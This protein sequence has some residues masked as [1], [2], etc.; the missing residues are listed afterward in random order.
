MAEEVR[1]YQVHRKYLPG[2]SRGDPM[3][4][5]I[6]LRVYPEDRRPSFGKGWK[7]IA[8]S[9][10]RKHADSIVDLFKFLDVGEG[11]LKKCE[12]DVEALAG[13]ATHAMNTGGI[14]EGGNEADLPAL[15]AMGVK[16][17]Q[18]QKE[19]LLGLVRWFMPNK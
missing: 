5:Q 16:H 8:E 18:E 19:R 2:T 10:T 13:I 6:F 14:H 11:E 15:R 9:K 12:R 4:Y 7:L 3:T 1:E 17:V